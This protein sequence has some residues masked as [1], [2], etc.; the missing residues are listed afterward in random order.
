[1]TR[2]LQKLAA[3]ADRPKRAR[4]TG[5]A[6]AAERKKSAQRQLKIEARRRSEAE[7]RRK[8]LAQQEARYNTLQEMQQAKAQAHAER[9][10]QRNA[11]RMAALKE[12]KERFESKQATIAALQADQYAK[13]MQAARDMESRL[14]AHT[15]KDAGLTGAQQIDL[16]AGIAPR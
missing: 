8:V 6:A 1:M 7:Q 10:K 2:E 16:P 11:D 4:N 15:S 9:V 3:K 12:K 14:K 5:G 13:D